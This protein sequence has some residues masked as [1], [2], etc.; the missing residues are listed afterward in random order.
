MQAL[1]HF[2]EAAT[3]DERLRHTLHAD[4]L[5]PR[6]EQYY[7]QPSEKP[8]IVDS[9]DFVRLDLDTDLGTGRHCIL[10]M[11]SKAWKFPVP[12]MLT[13]QPDGFK[14]D[15]PAFVEFKDR[16]LE[17]FFQN[18]Q[19]E[20]MRFH[21]GIQRN[22]F[23]GH[24]VP[25]VSHKDSFCLSPAPPDSFQG[26]AFLPKDTDFA[27]ELKTRLP[28]ETHVWAVVELEWKKQGAQQWVELKSVPQMHWYSL[29][30]A[31]RPAPPQQ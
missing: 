30:E 15:W 19:K 14:L 5:K 2:M 3:L 18:Y 7:K 13:E 31:S 4:I 17:K 23:F 1:K 25:D 6:M 10:S 11:E 21:V 27:A 20:P 16:Q 28:W 29:P 22:H 9:V 24:G 26:S 12:V 8:V